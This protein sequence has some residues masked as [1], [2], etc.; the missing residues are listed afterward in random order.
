MMTYSRNSLLVA[1]LTVVLAFATSCDPKEN[2]GGDAGNNGGDVVLVDG[3]ADGSTQDTAADTRPA[4]DMGKTWDPEA[5]ACLCDG[6]KCP[7]GSMCDPDVSACRV[8]VDG[9]CKSK[10][11]WSSGTTAF[12]EASDAW[13]LSDMAIDPRGVRVSVTDLEGD[14]WPDIVVRK[15][16]GDKNKFTDGTCKVSNRSGAKVGESCMDDA[17][18]RSNLCESDKCAEPS[19]KA[20]VGDVCTTDGDCQTDVCS[21][22]K[23]WVL[24]NTGNGSFEDVTKKSDLLASRTSGTDDINRPAEVFAWGDVDN[25]GDLD[26]YTGFNRPKP[27]SGIDDSA[28]IMLNNG[29]G[30]FKLT[31]SGNAIRRSGEPDMP[32]GASFLDYDRDAYLDLWVTQYGTNTTIAM[33]DQ[34][35]HGN[36]DGTFEK[37]TEKVGI[38]SVKWNASGGASTEQLNNAKGN[39][40]AWGSNACDLNGDGLPELLA[41]SYGR[42]PNHL[43][44]GVKRNG[45]VQYENVSVDSGY[46]YDDGTDWTDN[47]FARCH[48]KLH[49][50]DPDCSGVPAP[51][52]RCQNDGDV[53]AWRHSIGREKFRL[54]GNSGTTV[55]ADLNTDGRLDLLTNEI[56]HWWAGSSSDQSE[57]LYNKKGD[58]IRF[59]RPGRQKTGL[60]RQHNLRSWNEGDITSGV[61]DFDNDAR[62]DVYIGSTDYPGTR[63]LLWHQKADGTFE[64]VPTGDGIEHKRS[65]G[66]ALADF[67]RDGDV[68]LVAGHSP[69][70]CGDSQFPCYPRDEAH[71]RLFEN[72]VGSERNWIQ[73]ELVGGE[74]TNRAAI[75]ARVEVETESGTQ[76]QEVGGGH[77][78][79]GI[80]HDMTLTFGLGKAC[81]AKV[82]IRWP[83]PALTE[84]SFVLTSGQ[85]YRLE[86]GSA[87]EVAGK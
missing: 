84:Q 66:V 76:V 6:Q 40:R 3:G 52:I 69:A 73:L 28:E 56:T 12:E 77:G 70:R 37:V 85:R 68:D 60:T 80:Q 51:S 42:A 22:R 64:S 53:V 11:A 24:R 65:H 10:G 78:H 5:G 45:E 67:D 87:P 4:C 2:G 13:G 82:S 21:M 62:P 61:L 38:D 34:L 55:C 81:E 16:G 63:G 71:V 8:D 48:C 18:C 47:Q 30:T 32:A 83:D 54:G 49:P 41:A 17:D 44:K 72:K 31:P 20:A 39:S 50:S 59:E 23:V 46:A 57:I 79:Y 1:G 14:G 19:N 7:K 35:Y 75:G 33:R 74:K 29:D 26:A 86:Q 58:K 27:G 25:D 15:V 9:E 36:G 43:W